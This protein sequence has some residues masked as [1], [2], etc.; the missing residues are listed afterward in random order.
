MNSKLDRVLDT[1][2]LSY[3]YNDCIQWE[4]EGE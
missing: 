2:T 1:F 4:T 3:T